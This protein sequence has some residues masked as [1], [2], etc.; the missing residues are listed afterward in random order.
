MAPS[1]TTLAFV[2]TTTTS[3]KKTK[4]QQAKLDLE[5]KE[6]E[7]EE[8]EQEGGESVPLQVVLPQEMEEIAG[9]LIRSLQRTVAVSVQLQAKAMMGMCQ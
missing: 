9:R 8:Q 2:K 7:K 1:S 3:N 6:T 5:E 4:M